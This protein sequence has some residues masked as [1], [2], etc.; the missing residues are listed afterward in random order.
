MKS[1]RTRKQ[2]KESLLQQ[3]RAKG[4]DTVFYRDLVDKY[5]DLWDGVEEM[6]E[7]I[8]VRGRRY[9]S[10]SVSGKEFEKD[11]LSQ[12]MVPTY[13]KQMQSLLSDMG[14]SPD[15]IIQEGA[16]DDAL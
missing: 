15:K 10:V 13:L 1:K 3:L 7:D 5:M 11:N 14:I 12:K 6:L 2:I 9:S 8:R 4:A 16:D